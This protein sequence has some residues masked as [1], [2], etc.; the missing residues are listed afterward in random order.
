MM[1]HSCQLPLSHIFPKK[2]TPEAATEHELEEPYTQS[3][4]QA[5]SLLMTTP[6]LS[7]I[8]RL[9]WIGKA[10]CKKQAHRPLPWELLP[11]PPTLR[12]GKLR[13][14]AA[15]Q[16]P[17]SHYSLGRSSAVVVG[18]SVQIGCS[19]T[20]AAEEHMVRDCITLEI[21]CNAEFV[22]RNVALEIELI[23]GAKFVSFH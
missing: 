7:Y 8:Y 1:R 3:Y 9:E 4:F 10:H 5:K 12:G 22:C 18:T 15:I 20:P 11:A 16:L 2:Q 14:T 17:R 21:K 6:L 23:L 19:A 13:P